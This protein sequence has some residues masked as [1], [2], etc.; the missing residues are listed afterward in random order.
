MSSTWNAEIT[1]Y[2][3]VGFWN[4]IPLSIFEISDC[5]V[6]YFLEYWPW[7]NKN[8]GSVAV[9]RRHRLWR[10][11]NPQPIYW[12]I[13]RQHHHEFRRNCP[14]VPYRIFFSVQVAIIPWL[15]L[16]GVP[17]INVHGSTKGHRWG[18]NTWPINGLDI[19]KL[20]TRHHQSYTTHTSSPSLTSS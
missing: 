19:R 7:P 20:H 10:H 1:A 17:F 5:W 11:N 13:A 12:C 6:I 16:N 8:P 9:F 4:V 2:H 3:C 14:T 15:V 18:F